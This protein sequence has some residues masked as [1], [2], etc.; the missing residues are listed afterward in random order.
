MSDDK[1]IALV[2]FGIG[3]LCVTVSVIIVIDLFGYY[4]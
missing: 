1:K 4:K 2:Y 3:L